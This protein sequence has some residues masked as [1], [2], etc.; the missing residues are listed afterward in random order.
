MYKKIYK[1]HPQDLLSKKRN[2]NKKM[3]D[4]TL[5]STLSPISSL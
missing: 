3:S 1:P 4:L 5:G 2:V